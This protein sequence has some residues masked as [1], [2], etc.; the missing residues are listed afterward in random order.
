MK[1]VSNPDQKRSVFQFEAT[2]LSV[3][4]HRAKRERNE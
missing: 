3:V 1:S 4:S 2:I